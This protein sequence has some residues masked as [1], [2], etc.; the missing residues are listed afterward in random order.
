WVA[1]DAT[2]TQSNPT[3]AGA[4]TNT[5]WCTQQS[6]GDFLDW[7]APISVTAT[8]RTRSI[9]IAGNFGIFSLTGTSSDGSG[10]GG[11]LN[12]VFYN[13][14]TIAGIARGA[15]VSSDTQVAVSAWTDDT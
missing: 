10:V 6:N 1:T 13:N 2:L 7:N 5:T 15:T 8:T 11:T 3:H 12:L 4:C 14:T 9:D